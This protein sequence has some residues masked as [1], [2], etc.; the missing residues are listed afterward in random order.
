MDNINDA[1]REA[2]R[3]AV[4]TLSRALRIDW[5]DAYMLASLD[6]DIGVSQL[7]DPRKKAWARIPK[8]I[9]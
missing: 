9:I 4:E 3:V 1:L 6:V 2:A 5:V 8:H 7:V